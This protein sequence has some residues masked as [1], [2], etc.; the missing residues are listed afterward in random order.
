MTN[1]KN[2]CAQLCE[3]TPA[4]YGINWLTSA[5][6]NC[7]VIV[8][9]GYTASGE[10]LMFVEQN[11]NVAGPINA[12]QRD[13]GVECWRYTRHTHAK[14]L[15][16]PKGFDIDND[17]CNL[18]GRCDSSSGR[19]TISWISSTGS[20]P[21]ECRNACETAGNSCAGVVV[22]AGCGL[23]WAGAD[24]PALANTL[25]TSIFHKARGD[26]QGKI[27]SSDTQDFAD[28]ICSVPA[29]APAS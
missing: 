24:N 28:A 22:H 13:D 6:Q 19:I 8:H 29:V 27:D 3:D 17:W 11:T 16:C 4:C 21:A 7:Q 9:Q 25:H 15:W 2:E 1:S 23:V 5:S 10:L 20:T 18:A 14:N 12:L 26:F